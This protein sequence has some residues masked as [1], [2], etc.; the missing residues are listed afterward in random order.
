MRIH[1]FSQISTLINS[2]TFR[3]CHMPE[4]PF[5]ITLS[6]KSTRESFLRLWK[7]TVRVQQWRCREDTKQEPQALHLI[8]IFM[9]ILQWTKP[10]RETI[11]WTSHTLMIKTWRTKWYF[12]RSCTEQGSL[13]SLAYW[14][15]AKSHCSPRLKKNSKLAK[16]SPPAFA[17]C[18]T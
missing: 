1:L 13:N 2:K 3:D 6:Q 18:A 4:L 5:I 10:R 11:F 9:E 12:R 14:N 8:R 15:N 17:T 7:S 16:T